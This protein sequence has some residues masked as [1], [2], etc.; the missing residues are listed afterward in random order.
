MSARRILI[1]TVLAVVALAPV[2]A[3]AQ[4][5]PGLPEFKFARKGKMATP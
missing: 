1:V 5:G 3:L 4:M 2:F